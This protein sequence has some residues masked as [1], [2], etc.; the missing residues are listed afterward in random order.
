METAKVKRYDVLY[1]THIKKKRE[2]EVTRL[3]DERRV[4]DLPL[5]S[6]K[7]WKDGALRHHHYNSRMYLLA[8]DGAVLAESFYRPPAGRSKQGFPD[9]FVLDGEVEFE[10]GFLVEIGDVV[11]EG[12]TVN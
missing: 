1:T 12:T 5:P 9:T 8:E 2:L 10:A 7:T 4:P 11:W 3:F 6:E